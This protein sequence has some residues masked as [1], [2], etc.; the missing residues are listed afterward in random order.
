MGAGIFAGIRAGIFAGIRAGNCR[1]LAQPPA[2]QRPSVVN[3]YGINGDKKAKRTVEKNAVIKKVWNY[4]ARRTALFGILVINLNAKQG[5][6]AS[7]ADTAAS[8]S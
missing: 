8:E 7:E 4:N 1:P 5:R 6:P 3:N 2:H